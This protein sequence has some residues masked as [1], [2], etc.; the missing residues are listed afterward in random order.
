[1]TRHKRSWTFIPAVLF[2]S[3]GAVTAAGSIFYTESGA[4]AAQ[5][6]SPV[7]LS[8]LPGAV[9]KRAMMPPATA[10]TRTRTAGKKALQ[11]STANSATDADSAWLEELDIDGDGNVEETNLVWD[12]EDKVLYAFSTG[13]FA[14]RNGGTAM[15]DL[16]VAANGPGNSRGRPPGSGFWVADLD[17]G[18]CAAEAAGLWGCRFDGGG[19]PTACGTARVD[20]RNDL[21][22]VTAT[23]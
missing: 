7:G 9:A 20:A 22:I 23:H 1:M 2:L 12:D 8:V 14:C 21:I 5:S 15:A 3:T 17:K 4:A 10:A 13:T 18:E 16:L 11:L 19:N 6:S